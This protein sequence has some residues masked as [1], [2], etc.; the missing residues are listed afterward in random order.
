MELS[1]YQEDQYN[2][3]KRLLGDVN[4]EKLLAACGDKKTET[5]RPGRLNR[6]ETKEVESSPKQDGAS[7]S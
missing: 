1:P 7:I 3:L 2:H 5:V 6:N 4:V